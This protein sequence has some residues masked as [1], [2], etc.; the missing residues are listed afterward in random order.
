LKKNPNYWRKDAAGGALPYLDEIRIL[1]MPDA[2]AMV[3]QM[4]SGALDLIMRPTLTDVV[5]LQKNAKF[6][7]FQGM[8]RQLFD[9]LLLTTKGPFAANKYLR[10]AVSNIVNREQ[11]WKTVTLGLGDWQCTPWPSQSQAYFADLAKSIKPD[12]AKAKAL[13]AQGG[14]PNGF[15]TSIMTSR[16]RQQ[17]Y[18]DIAVLVQQDL[19][20]IGIQAKIDEVDNANYDQ[21]HLNE[22]FEVAVHSYARSNYDPDTLIGGAKA[23]TPSIG[24]TRF[25]EQKYIDLYTDAG[26][27]YDMAAR[28]PKY[29]TLTEYILDQSFCL[30]LMYNPEYFIYG[31]YVVGTD[32]DADYNTDFSQSWL[33]K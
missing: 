24:M 26:S 25:G 8:P 16:Q 11:Y 14:Q 1:A 12:V 13:L 29:R 15:Q 30:P 17:E 32:A 19:A 6:G 9:I 27:S 10:Q 5:R 28:K 18:S 7:V 22:G 23:W 33:D 4:E 2:T 3:T 21:R 31:S 20:K